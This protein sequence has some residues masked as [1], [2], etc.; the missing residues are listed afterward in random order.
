MEGQIIARQKSFHLEDRA[1]LHRI[2]FEKGTIL[3]DGVEHPLNDRNFPTIDPAD[4]YRLSEAEQKLMEHLH[5]SFLHSERLQKHVRFL[6]KNGGMYLTFNSNLLYHGCIPLE[7]DGS[8]SQVKV[9]K[10]IL[11]GKAYLDYADQLARQ[12]YF[13]K[14]GTKEKA[15][16][17]DFMWYLWCG[18]KS[19]L[20]G[21]NRIT[22]LS[23]ISSTTRRPGRKRRIPTTATWSRP[24]PPK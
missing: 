19:P 22:T 16:A 5:T 6:Y 11:S 8:F 2:D 1:L 21:K 23:G 9:G 14:E 20:N 4:P 3:I 17:V 13:G 24:R 18:P 7:P 15:D 10:H 12:A